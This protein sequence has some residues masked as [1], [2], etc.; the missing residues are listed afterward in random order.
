MSGERTQWRALFLAASRW[1]TLLPVLTFAACGS[2]AAPT[3]LATVPISTAPTVATLTTTVSVTP[4]VV[5]TSSRRPLLGE[6]F[7]IQGGGTMFVDVLAQVDAT[8]TTP[9]EL[10]FDAVLAD[11]RCPRLVACVVRGDAEVAIV[12]Q[13]GPNHQPQTVTLH[14]DPSL[15]Q[16]HAVY[17]GYDISLVALEPTADRPGDTVALNA[18]M[19]TLIVTSVMPISPTVLPVPSAIPTPLNMIN[20]CGLIERATL[21]ERFGAIQGEPLSQA[22]AAN[23][24]QQCVLQ[25]ERATVTMRFY[26]GDTAIAQAVIAD[27]QQ[28]G[29]PF[30]EFSNSTGS[31][32]AFG[33]N[34]QRAVLVQQANEAIFLIEIAFTNQSQPSDHEQAHANL[35][36]LQTMLLRRYISVQAGQIVLPTVQPLP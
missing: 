6:R 9:L 4:A 8:T 25:A 18:Y 10:R 22:V 21:V 14:T 36:A 15:A 20:M 12:A 7:S 26:Q 31:T 23:N 5:S 35:N 32:A 24:G 11:N 29:T 27:A 2:A 30:T 34:Q 17:E 16:G 13:L 19:A 28:A 3:P 1:L 33:E